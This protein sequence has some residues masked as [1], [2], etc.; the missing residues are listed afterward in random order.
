MADKRDEAAGGERR[1]GGERGASEPPIDVTIESSPEDLERGGKVAAS[2]KG[3]AGGLDVQAHTSG[4]GGALE[5]SEDPVVEGPGRRRR[6]TRSHTKP[7][8]SKSGGGSAA[9]SESRDQTLGVTG[10]PRTLLPMTLCVCVM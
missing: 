1:P 7:P 4:A 8:G 10:P 9:K 6:V 2:P 5:S 3:D